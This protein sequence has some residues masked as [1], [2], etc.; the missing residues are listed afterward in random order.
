MTSAVL[1]PD[2]LG[3]LSGAFSDLHG[4][5]QKKEDKA[6]VRFIKSISVYSLQPEMLNLPGLVCS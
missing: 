6:F 1:L 3:R 2:G 5:T 4:C